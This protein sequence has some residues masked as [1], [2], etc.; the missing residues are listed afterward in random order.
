MDRKTFFNKQAQNWEKEHQCEKE[1]SKLRKLIPFLPIKEGARVLDAGC[2][3]G[4]L[5]P[6]IIKSAGRT[7][8][9]VEMDFARKMLD[10]AR[11]KHSNS[12]ICFVQSDAQNLP[13]KDQLFDVVVCFAL[14]P[15]IPDKQRALREFHR[16]LKPKSPFVIAHTM[17]REELNAF[18]KKVKGPVTQDLLPVKEEMEQLFLKAGFQ[19]F[20]LKDQPSLYIAQGKA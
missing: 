15:H 16:I 13:F 1:K 12:N 6:Y 4:R 20:S 10:I 7:G 9:I 19:N 17:S 3:T 8:E 14:L 2:G 5:I 18:H 11:L